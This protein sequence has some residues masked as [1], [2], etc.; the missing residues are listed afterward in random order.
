MASSRT[1]GDLVAVANCDEIEFYG[2]G[3]KLIGMSEFK[4]GQMFVRGATKVSSWPNAVAPSGVGNVQVTND[5]KAITAEFSDTSLQADEH[6]FSLLLTD[7]PGN[8][9]PL[10]YTQNTSIHPNADGTIQSVTYT[11]GE[12]EDIASSANIY[13]LVDTYPVYMEQE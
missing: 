6:V 3:L 13:V 11:V 5:G 9:L 7:A 2:I 4:T 10:Y 1:I 8:P 12:D